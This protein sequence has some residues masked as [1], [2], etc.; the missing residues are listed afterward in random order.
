MSA[1]EIQTQ[2]DARES[3][4]SMILRGKNPIERPEK[5][6]VGGGASNQQMLVV[7]VCS[8]LDCEALV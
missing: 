1:I 4:I 2:R 3:R 5:K 6:Q 7:P 8:P